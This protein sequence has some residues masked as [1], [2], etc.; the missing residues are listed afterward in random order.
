MTGIRRSGRLLCALFLTGLGFSAFAS[1]ASAASATYG[2]DALGRLIS[3]TNSNG[4]SVTYSYDA[5]GNRKEQVVSVSRPIAGAVGTNVRVNSTNSAIAPKLSGAAATGVAISATPVH[6][7]A[8]TSGMSLLYTP[9]AG[10][11]GQDSFQYI[12]LSGSGNSDPAL[13]VVNVTAGGG[14]VVLPLPGLPI[15]VLPSS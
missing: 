3:V 11:A 8:S 15:I 9:T 6:G 13:V 7:A 2:Y 10:F 4:S 1:A 14:V 12:A 5:A